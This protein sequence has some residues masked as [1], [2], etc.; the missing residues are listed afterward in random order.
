MQ[1]LRILFKHNK[2][3]GPNQ[4]TNILKLAEVNQWNEIVIVW[5][6]L[7]GSYLNAKASV[8]IVTPLALTV[9]KEQI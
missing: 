3:K 1:L 6:H 8:D 2:E 5:L 7:H 9:N 4:K